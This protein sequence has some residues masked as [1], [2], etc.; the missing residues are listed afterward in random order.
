VLLYALFDAIY[1]LLEEERPV[2]E[3]EIFYMSIH[4]IFHVFLFVTLIVGAIAGNSIYVLPWLIVCFPVFAIV[5]YYTLKYSRF[6]YISQFVVN[7][8]FICLGWYL[9]FTVYQFCRHC[10]SVN[11]RGT[12]T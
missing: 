12:K 3:S 5:S 4:V 7:I 8:L 11:Q 10:K 6:S 2:T 1:D 9:W